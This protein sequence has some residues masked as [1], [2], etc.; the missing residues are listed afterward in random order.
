M[1]G[2]GRG[3]PFS[4]THAYVVTSPDAEAGGKKALELACG[5]LCAQADSGRPCLSCPECRRVLSGFHPD[6]VR[7]SRETDEKGKQKKDIRVG[8]IRRMAAD[9]YV[10]PSQAEAKVYIIEDADSMNVS[11]QNAALKILEEPPAYAVFILCAESAEALL[12]TVRSRC[13]PIRLAG[14]RPEAEN[15]L[16]DRYIRL[17]AKRDE[18]GVCAFFGEN[19]SLDAERAAAL[20]AGIRASLSAFV[21]FR[22]DCEGLTREDAFRLLSL[23][24]RAGAYLRLNVGVKHVMGLLCAL[25]I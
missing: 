19:E 18:K 1:S 21:C 10:R 8:Q 2:I 5:F 3:A 15:A 25:T 20:I 7:I 13:V 17:A 14:E 22:K 23:C 24:D 9:A 16:A 6:V 11:A 12:P 4:G